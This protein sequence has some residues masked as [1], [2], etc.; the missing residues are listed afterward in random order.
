MKSNPIRLTKAMLRRGTLLLLQ[1][2]ACAV[3]VARAGGV[4]NPSAGQDQL[5]PS[6]T[7]TPKALPDDRRVNAGQLSKYDFKFVLDSSEASGMEI[8]L[9]QLALQKS[10]TKSVQ[11]FARES[12]KEHTKAIQDLRRLAMQKGERVSTNLAPRVIEASQTLSRS[13]DFDRAYIDKTINNIQ[14]ELRL[15]EEASSK[16]NDKEVKQYAADLIPIVEKR[17]EAAKALNP[18]VAVKIPS[19]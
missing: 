12:I 8:E 13:S 19:G 5:D 7:Q 16:G 17:L 10:K 15:Y 3:L 18:S 11:E 6:A 2:S 1:L 9:G 14:N 4:D